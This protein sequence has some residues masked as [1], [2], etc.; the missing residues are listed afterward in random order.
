[1]TA[2]GE[3]TSVYEKNYTSILSLTVCCTIFLGYYLTGFWRTFFNIISFPKHLHITPTAL[4]MTLI[5]IK[6]QIN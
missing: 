2:K 1:M 5:K 6:G 4:S 3:F